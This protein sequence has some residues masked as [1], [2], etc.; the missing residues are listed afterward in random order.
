MPTAFLEIVELEDG[1]IVLRRGDDEGELVTLEF[2]EEA[3][4]FLQGQHLE[5]AKVMLNAGLQMAGQ[6]AEG[7]LRGIEDE[8]RV[9]H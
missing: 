9:L 5:V 4:A 2:S 6:L 1:R 8:P 3:R 7:D